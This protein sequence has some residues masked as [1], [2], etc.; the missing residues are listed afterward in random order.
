MSKWLLAL[1]ICLLVLLQVTTGIANAQQVPYNNTY[2]PNIIKSIDPTTAKI[3]SFNALPVSNYTGR[4][5]ISVPIF[6]IK[7]SE[8][9]SMPVDLSYDVSSTKVDDIPSRNG[10]GWIM[11]VVGNIS[12]N[13]RDVNDFHIAIYHT[14]PLGDYDQG[15]TRVAR[16]GWLRT[17]NDYLD[18]ED[19]M[20]DEYIVSAPGLS[21]RFIIR[22]D[23]TA[24]ELTNQKIRSN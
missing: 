13:V 11:N 5:S 8:S 16:L 22:K 19:A 21:T 14:G 4:P 3:H 15:E 6:N 7:L 24:M 12:R 2:V 23:L 20:P 17:T 10:F 9:F 18:Y 1:T